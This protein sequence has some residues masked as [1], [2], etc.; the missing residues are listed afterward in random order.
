[1]AAD[2][3]ATLAAL[4][5]H[6]EEVFEPK[7][8]EYH[9][10]IVKLMGDGIL[11][12][13]ASVID[14]VQCAM[15][16]Q[17]EMAERNAEVDED[18]RLVFRIGVN[19]GDIIIEGDD[20]YGD[21]V[22]V[23]AR[24]EGL[25]EPGGI[26]ISRAARDQVRDK[27]PIKFEDL[28]EQQ[29]KN[30]PRPIRAFGVLLE[31]PNAGIAPA[32]A[33]PVPATP[34]SEKP[35]IAILPFTNMS[36]DPEQEYFSDGITEDIITGLSKNRSFFVISRGTSFKYKGAS[37]DVSQVAQE[38]AVRYVLE[39]SVRKAGN[40][41]RISAQLSDAP[42]N[43]QVWA[44]RYDKE[45]EDIFDVQDEITRNIIGAIAPGIMSAEIQRA[46]R[47]EARDL[48]AWDLIMRAHWH[49]RQFTKDDAVKAQ[50]LLRQALELEA[51]N[52]MALADLAFAGHFEIVFGWSDDP[53]ASFD[54][55]ADAARKAVAADDQNAMA[56]TALAIIELFADRHDDA[57]RRMHMACDLD[58]NL[59]IARGYLGVTYAFAGDPEAAMTHLGQAVQ[60][61]P[62]EPLL[63]IWH[64]AMGWASLAAEQ[65]GDA[66]DFAKQAIEDHPEFTD[67]YGVLAAG[68]GQLEQA[69]E[70]GAALAQLVRRMP[71]LTA[72]DERLRRPF[73]RE[74]DR[75]RFVEGLVK[76]GLAAE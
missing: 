60:M 55:V 5:R 19:L 35:S 74:T 42:V 24:L 45:L 37:V 27:V 50:G 69:E 66:V 76:A 18:R 3:G 2:E 68:H 22:N 38:L 14:A 62:R 40:R 56:H 49:I 31:I 8:A 46:Q 25:A 9:G 11:A 41:V 21:G 65:Y 72:N 26:C 15:E 52:A 29:V 64:T 4:K 67:S 39:G 23:A 16:I 63:V 28:G 30:I 51:N 7:I 1:M 73:K 32:P 71:G 6:R 43:H 61:G 48:E 13:F 75:Q 12:E 58:P 59:A 33:K 53:A 36:G 47:K 54:M 20:I 70:A 10:R 44:E 57:V 34:V 17:Q